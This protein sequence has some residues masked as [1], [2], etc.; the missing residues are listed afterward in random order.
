MTPPGAG[1][2]R[3]TV[4]ADAMDDDDNQATGFPPPQAAAA[5]APPP[6]A[7]GPPPGPSPST[8]NI[9]NSVVDA[10]IQSHRASAQGEP[11]PPGR[12]YAS[13]LADVVN[14]AR[15][16][17]APSVG[18]RMADAATRARVRTVVESIAR[19]REGLPQ[20]VT[21]ERLTRDATAEI[22][23][24]GAIE[25]ALEEP[26]VTTVVVESSGRVLVGRGDALGPSPLW[27]SGDDAVTTAVDRLL[28]ANGVARKNESVID[29]TLTDGTRL[30][31]V[32][33]PA[34]PAGPTVVVERPAG[35]VASLID[36]VARSVLSQ[37]AMGLLGHA[38]TARR[39]IVVAGPVGSG[40]ST[41]LG[42]LVAAV[43]QHDRCVLVESR[44]HLGRG[45][46][47]VTSID[48]QG[49]WERAMDVALRLRP[50]RIVVADASEA[51]A[52]ALVGML[53]TGVEG[54]LFVAEGPSPVSALQRLASAAAGNGAG[55]RED[56]LARLA[57]SRPLLVQMARLA[58]GTCRVASIGEARPADGGIHVDEAFAL[59]VDATP[60]GGRIEAS[61]VA[62]GIVPAFAAN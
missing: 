18:D 22:S 8:M 34:A 25:S 15:S 11:V 37:Q 50:Q 45:L 40:R 23:G 24:A 14:E 32:F 28:H 2:G 9:A 39:N 29:A 1:A 7:G 47:D 41:V 3:A 53:V 17:G 51:A 52:G 6:S 46:R 4:D 26:E 55:T 49:D 36:L 20:G 33:P 12:E 13:A 43:L 31:A 44:A 60:A 42:A 35:R 30:T 57:A 16:N 38:L 54:A 19:R 21:P 59:R 10:V 58:D 62:T 61:L 27:F 56:A 48:P 5:M